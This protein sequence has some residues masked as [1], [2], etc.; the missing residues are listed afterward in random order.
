[1]FIK[2]SFKIKFVM[3]FLKKMSLIKICVFNLIKLFI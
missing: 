3:V 1:M 2:K